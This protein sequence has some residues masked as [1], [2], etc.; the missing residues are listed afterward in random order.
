ME[1]RVSEIRKRLTDEQFLNVL[2][3]EIAESIATAS[4]E[5]IL[6]DARLAGDDVEKVA[7][8]TKAVL[9]GALEKWKRGALEPQNCT[10]A[11]GHDGP[12]NGWPCEAR[13]REMEP[14]R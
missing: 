14:P 2:F 1:D 12:C 3:D 6:E 8:D 9:K 11:E 7:A 10:R 4:D 13:R 5:E